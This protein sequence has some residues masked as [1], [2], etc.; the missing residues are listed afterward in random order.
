MNILPPLLSFI[1]GA[2]VAHIELIT[3]KYPRTFFL[4]KKSL[5]LYAYTSIYGILSLIGMLVLES[6]IRT[7]V[8]SLEGLGI[9]SRWIQAVVVGVS[10]KALLHI[11]LFKVSFRNLSFPV[12]VETFVFLFEPWLLRTID[13]DEFNAVRDYHFFSYFKFIAL[14]ENRYTD[15]NDVKTK[16]E[17]NIPP[18]LS[19]LEKAAFLTDLKEKDTVPEAMELYLQSFGK[20]SFERVFPLNNS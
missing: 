3:S 4:L 1:I 20:R 9:S 2:L 8:I 7:Q 15:L 16:I 6:L 11:R 5:A 13:L 10:T 18:T 14:A 19:N 17:D 12:G